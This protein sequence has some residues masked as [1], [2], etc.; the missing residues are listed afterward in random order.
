MYKVTDSSGK[1]IRE[2][3]KVTSS[4]DEAHTFKYVTRGPLPGKSAKVLTDQGEFYANVFDLI[5]VE[6]PQATPLDTSR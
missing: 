5:V 3:D 1:E 4:R 6:I 2:G